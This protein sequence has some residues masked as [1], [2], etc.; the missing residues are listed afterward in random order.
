MTDVHAASG[1]W[2]S[3]MR[4]L[5]DDRRSVIAAGTLAAV[6]VTTLVGPLVS[7]Y[8]PHEQLDI[9]NLVHARP[10]IA[11]LLGTDAYSRDVLSRI[12]SGGRIS[13][14]V[15]ASAVFIETLV[16]I[17]WGM[18]AGLA[19]G[20]T[21]TLMMRCVDA[22]MSVPRVLLLLALLAA[23]PQVPLWLLV[24]V[25]GVTGWFGTAR[26]VRGEVRTMR[27]ADFVLAARSLGARPLR[28]AVRH[29]LPQV[30]GPVLVASTLAIGQVIVLEA[31]LSWLGIGVQPPQ[32]SWGNIIRDGYE[33]IASAPWVSLA[34][35]VCLVVVVLA[36]SALGDGLRD[37]LAPGQL[38]R[39]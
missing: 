16:G 30:M 27:S 29:L 13:L 6:V 4:R 12:L 35:G 14:A 8:A 19:G 31:G 5:R 26:L 15:A 17:A 3:V 34:P 32:A 36:V 1:N 37:A 39:T 2:R 20:R 25:L 33:F 11:H 38:P 21:D 23:V 18:C 28:I 24:L 22:G 10:G 7:A 9:A